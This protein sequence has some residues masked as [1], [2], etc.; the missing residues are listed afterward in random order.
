MLIIQDFIT[1]RNYDIAFSN[2]R[3]SIDEQSILYP[4]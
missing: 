3:L 1:F 2:L 4:I